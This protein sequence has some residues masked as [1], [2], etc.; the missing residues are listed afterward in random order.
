[1]NS[2]VNGEDFD[3]AYKVD[4][5]H[6]FLLGLCLGLDQISLSVYKLEHL[7]NLSF[8]HFKQWMLRV[9][10]EII[11]ARLSPLRIWHSDFSFDF[12]KWRHWH[13]CGKTS[14]ITWQSRNYKRTS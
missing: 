4:S 14:D 5:P 6:E 13:M 8:G 11:N 10:P 7:L 2:S 9:L 3:D 12:V 1:M